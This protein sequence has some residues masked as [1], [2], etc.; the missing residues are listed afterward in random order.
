MVYQSKWKLFHANS[1]SKFD[2]NAIINKRCN[3]IEIQNVITKY[4]ISEKKNS[5]NAKKNM[6][7]MCSHSRIT[8]R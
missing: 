5:C 2:V 6:H 3:S 1:I 8:S 7:L 4:I